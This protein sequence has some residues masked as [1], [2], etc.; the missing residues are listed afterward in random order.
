MATGGTGG[1]LVGAPAGR[2]PRGLGPPVP[3]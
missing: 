2:T 1:P 3:V